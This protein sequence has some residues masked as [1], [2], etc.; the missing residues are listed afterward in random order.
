MNTPV[1]TSAYDDHGGVRD[2]LGR[3]VDGVP[4]QA[5]PVT[6]AVFARA[7]R[8][9]WRR[10]AAVTGAA[11][12][13][14]A[15]AVVLG[16][17][18]LPDGPGTPVAASPAASRFGGGAEGFAKLL[19]QGI[20]K[21]EEVSLGQLIKGTE[22]P[23]KPRRHVGPYDGEYSVTR[24]GGAGFLT[25]RVTAPAGGRGALPHPCALTGETP[26]KLDCT[27]EQVSGGGRLA[28]W[29][30]DPQTQVRPQFSGAELTARLLLQD[31][32]VLTVRDWTGFTG[33]GSLGPVLKEFP[34][35]RD[36]LRELA[37]EPELL[38]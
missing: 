4:A 9:R 33:D 1:N 30:T 10:R 20:G 38:P 28:L 14:V 21:I 13:A 34:L 11:A 32:T 15:G 22:K 25:V 5:G 18:A 31:G 35:T 24:D 37:L 36:Q 3:A 29:R 19:P 2:L 8:L 12:A 26:R 7:A 27:E 23:L 6:E 17:G 16:S